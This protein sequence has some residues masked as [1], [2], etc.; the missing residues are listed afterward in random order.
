VTD[1]AP[2][3][4]DGRRSSRLAA[5]YLSGADLSR[6]ASACVFCRPWFSRVGSCS[7]VRCSGRRLDAR[8]VPADLA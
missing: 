2:R 6:S 3:R 8:A 4:P 1:P 7:R 5:I